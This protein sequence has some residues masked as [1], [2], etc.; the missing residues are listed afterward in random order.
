[1]PD[2]SPSILIKEPAIPFGSIVLVTGVNGL[3]GSHIAN[4]VLF[5]GYHVRGTVRDL[6]RSAWLEPFFARR[7]PKVRF[8]LVKIADMSI[9]GCF[10]EAVKGCAGVIHTTSSLDLQATK[11]EPTI[12]LATKTVMT[13]LESAA[14]ASKVRRFVLT[15]SA[16]AIAS[17]KIDTEFVISPKNWNEEAVQQAYA[18]D[19]PENNSMN[20]F[21]AG[22]TLAEKECWKF[23]EQKKPCFI[24][25]AVLP[26]TVFGQVLSPT[27]QGIPS[28]AGLIHMLFEGR[29]LDILQWISPQHYID[30]EDVGRLHVAALVH[31]STSNER[32]PGHAGPWNW[33]DILAL[34]REW[35][36]DKTFIGDFALGRDISTVEDRRSRELLQEV[37][38]QT[39]WVT[40]KDS[41][42]ATVDS[43]MK[44]SSDIQSGMHGAFSQ[45]K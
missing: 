1:M 42:R 30:C 12:S 5:A 17:P 20:I 36:P 25:N 33:N 26:D 27:N 41:T 24:L 45:T 4:Q 9:D 35:Y 31:P 2:M 6:E 19:P 11:P 8:E 13:C 34:F 40:L 43:F 23:V 37:Y 18:K 15:S 29:N 38:G 7:H 10:N 32:L 21:M 14:R 28:T 16:W 3:L 44:D 39:R 22:K